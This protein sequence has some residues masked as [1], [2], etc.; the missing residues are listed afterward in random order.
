MMIALPGGTSIVHVVMT[1]GRI[2]MRP[3]IGS[4]LA[5]PHNFGELCLPQAEGASVAEGAW[6]ESVLL[7]VI[8]AAAHNL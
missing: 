6:S 5:H 3:S 2:G 1:T 8:L 4:P 7:L